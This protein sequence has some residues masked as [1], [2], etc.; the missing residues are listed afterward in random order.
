MA[1]HVLAVLA[2]VPNNFAI[3]SM[4]NVASFGFFF[5]RRQAAIVE[6][7]KHASVGIGAVGS[8]LL[9]TKFPLVDLGGRGG[10]R[11]SR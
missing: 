7:F 5:V 2:P 9:I 3:S 6:L 4:D 8:I 11:W 1:G 10:S